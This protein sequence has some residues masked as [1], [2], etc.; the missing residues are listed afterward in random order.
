MKKTKTIFCCQECGY[1][2]FKWLGR[3]PE[4]GGWDCF[5]EERKS[6][7]NRHGSRSEKSLSQ[8]EP[9]S[10]DSI[11]ID[12]ENRTLTGIDE[13]DR[14]LGGGVVAGSLVPD[15][16]RSGHRQVYPFASGHPWAGGT[17]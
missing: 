7:V 4:C 17:R 3:C 5:V 11:E 13:F 2:A 9:V 1:Q 14:V 10:I 15:R 12:D 6:P 16:R 8:S